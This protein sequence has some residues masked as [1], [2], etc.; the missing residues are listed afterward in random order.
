ML[1]AIIG[2]IIGSR[3]ETH[4]I[5]SKKF[6]LFIPKISRITDDSVLT[7]AVA[8]S[9]LNNI[10]ISDSLKKWSEKFPKVGYGYAFRAWIKQ[11]KKTPYYSFGNGSAMR[12][13]SVGWLAN[14]EEEVKELSKKVTEI[15]HD[16]PEGLKGAEVTAM[17][18][19]YARIGKDKKFI[20]K[21]VEQYY[22]LNLSYENLVR[23]YKFDVSC[24]GSVPQAIFCFLISN[25]FEDCIRNSISIGGDSDTIAAISGAIAEAYYGIPN[26]IKS[27]AQKYIPNDIKKV[28]K[29]FNKRVF[30]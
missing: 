14:S 12:V 25:D 23:N 6:V 27:E 11:D 15:T 19:Y 5:K 3:F 26:S 29:K 1:G 4:N 28:I 16:H 30:K 9:I 24:Q 7:T 17:C 18:V 13:S 2:D 10:H 20:K 22:N 8:D 21:Y